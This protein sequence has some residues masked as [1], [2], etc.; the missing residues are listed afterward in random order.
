MQGTDKPHASSGIP[1]FNRTPL[2]DDKTLA[3][4]IKLY[5]PVS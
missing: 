4:M 1:K 5:Q 2:F 3:S